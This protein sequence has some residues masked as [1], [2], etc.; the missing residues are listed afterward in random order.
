MSIIERV[1]GVGLV[2]PLVIALGVSLVANLALFGLWRINRAESAAAETNL[3][4][5]VDA[6]AGNMTLI[7]AQRDAL[8]ACVGLDQFVAALATRAER[9]FAA[10]QAERAAAA[11]NRRNARG[12]TY[13][14]DESCR[15]WAA[16]PMCPVVSDSL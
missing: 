3:G 4:A 14:T 11:A 6:N 15:T 9:D 8:D 5:A 16:V 7:N 13:A 10:A 2:Q 1:T 12:Q